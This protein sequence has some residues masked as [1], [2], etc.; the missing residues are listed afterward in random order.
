MDKQTIHCGAARSIEQMMAAKA[1]LAGLDSP[2]GE[3]AIQAVQSRLGISKRRAK[4]LVEKQAALV[5]HDVRLVH[6][7]LNLHIATVITTDGE[8]A[9]INRAYKAFRQIFKSL[10]LPNYRLVCGCVSTPLSAVIER[11]ASRR[12]Q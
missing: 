3:P 9:A 8:D 12:S 11:N 6:S 1:V 7:G 4:S 10:E 2:A 5:E